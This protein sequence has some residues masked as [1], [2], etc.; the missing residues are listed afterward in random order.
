MASALAPSAA[1]ITSSNNLFV[2]GVDGEV[3][4]ENA[5]LNYDNARGRGALPAPKNW[6]AALRAKIGV[7][8][9]PRVMVFATAGYT[10]ADFDYSKGYWLTE[11]RP[12]WVASGACR[13]ASAPPTS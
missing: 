3:N 11:R 9:N 1:I 5:A 12:N 10:M 6:S 8:V 4:W 2:L 13:S 7:V